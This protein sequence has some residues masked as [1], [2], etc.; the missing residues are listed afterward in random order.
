MLLTLLKVKFVVE[1]LEA[2]K[3]KEEKKPLEEFIP[4]TNQ[5]IRQPVNDG[6]SNNNSKKTIAEHTNNVFMVFDILRN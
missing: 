6:D 5:A 3:R 2:K 4:T 1:L